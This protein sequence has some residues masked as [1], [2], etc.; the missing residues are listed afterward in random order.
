MFSTMDKKDIFYISPITDF[1][2][3]KCFRDEVVMKG[4]LVALF[5]SVGIELKI[6]NITYLNNESDGD[7][8]DR[9]RIIYDIKCKLD[10]G[11]EFIVEMQ[12]ER[13]SFIDRRMM[14]Y[15]ARGISQQG[16]VEGRKGKKKKEIEKRGWDYN[17]NK[18]IGVFLLNFTIPGEEK[19]KVSRHCIV[20]MKSKEVSNDLLEFWKIQLP[21]YRKGKFKEKNCKTSLDYWLFNLANMDKMKTTMPFTEKS[22]GLFR[23]N[24]LAKYHSLSYADQERYLKEYDDYVVYNDVMNLKENEGEARGEQKA[25]CQIAYKLKMK[26]NS[27]DMIAEVTGLSPEEIEKL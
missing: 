25:K 8:Q 26:G 12:N 14:Y 21:Y 17:I 1:G 15:M 19:Y 27:I 24:E 23:L 22:A 18:V 6:E 10:S 11:D 2:F 20:N 13:Q 4:F 3:K 5:E 9:H 7:K 16:V